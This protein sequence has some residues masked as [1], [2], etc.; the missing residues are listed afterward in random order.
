MAYISQV[1]LPNNT[2][3]DIKDTSAW[4]AIGTLSAAV[5]A[6]LQLEVVTTLPT[7]SSNTMGKIY[8][9][10]DT[11]HDPSQ[12]TGWKD[13]YDE[14]VTVKTGTNTYTWEKIGNTD[15]NLS[16]YSLKTHTHTYGG[17]TG[18]GSAHSHT[19][20]DVS[21][22][23]IQPQ[24]SVPL[25]FDTTSFVTGVSTSKLVV[26]NAS[27]A[28]PGT[29]IS[30]AAVGEAVVYGKADVGSSINVGTSLS[31]TKTF[32]TNAI[33]SASLSGTK[34][35]T[36][37]G[38]TVTA[39]SS[40]SE[41]LTFSS[42]GTGTVGIST[43]AADTGTVSLSTT[44]ITPATAAPNTQTI[45]PATSGGS[46]T[47][48]TFT[49]VSVATGKVAN[50]GSGATIAT[51]SSGSSNGYSSVATSA[52]LLKNTT[53]NTSTNAVKIVT[54]VPGT[55]GSES[56]HTHDYSGTTDAANS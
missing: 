4:T 3:Y 27:K 46:I 17:T 51:G 9:K 15:V 37:E 31:G 22:S 41:L 19:I 18:T 55:T 13:I 45:T 2:T 53:S 29:S 33:K 12:G 1:K 39:P 48:Y 50:N 11:S 21:I 49:D 43:E 44:S 28:T 23:Y 6:G 47:P 34:T 5:G 8:L 35:F 16:N 42:A 25:T 36:T 32:N 14:Y 10:S 56:S 20:T 52:T 26:T 30:V 38:I 24:T 54:A 40:G 7:A